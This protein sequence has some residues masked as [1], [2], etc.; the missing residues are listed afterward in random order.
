[1]ITKLPEWYRIASIAPHSVETLT[2]RSEVIASIIER[3]EIKWLFNCVRLFLSKKYDDDFKIEFIKLFTDSDPLFQQNDN[4]LELRVLCGAIVHQYII[5]YEYDESIVLALSLMSANFGNKDIINH[6]IIN[7]VN[8][9]LNNKSIEL[10]EQNTDLELSDDIEEEDVD[11]ETVE[12]LD[13]LKAKF[14]NFYNITQM[15]EILNK[16]VNNIA[17]LDEESNIH[18]WIFRGFSNFKTK[19]IKDLDIEIAP[20]VLGKDL[21][22]LTKIIPGPIA[23]EQYI[24]KL[25]NDCFQGKSVDLLIFKDVINKLERVDK[26]I[27]VE[28]YKKTNIGNLCPILFAC[29]ESLKIDDNKNWIAYFEKYSGLKAKTKYGIIDL[30]KQFYVENLLVKC[31]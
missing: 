19:P 6:D 30:A 31:I 5:N 16:L 1:M 29:Q 11:E 15:N 4:E 17:I 27:F 3:K 12:T 21:S 18:W 7:D 20:I 24:M 23:S 14:E 28:N 25:I 10:R 9:Y 8:V 22:D 13:T 2:S 26:E